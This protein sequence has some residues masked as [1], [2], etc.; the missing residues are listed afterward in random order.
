[1]GGR[2]A[3][4]A[5]EAIGF[6]LT[7]SGAS[8]RYLEGKVLS[9]T[10]A[11]LRL[12]ARFEG[13]RMGIHVAAG[14]QLQAENLLAV[15]AVAL[16]FGLDPEAFRCFETFC[17]VPGR[18]ERILN[19]QNLD[20]F[21]DY[22]HT[23][24]RVDQ[25]PQRAAW[26]GLQA[27]RHRVRLRGQ[28]RPQPSARSWAKPWPGCPT[29]PCLPPTI[30]ATRSPRRSWPTS[31]PASPGA[32]EVFADPDRRRAIEK[33]LELLHPGDALLIAGKGHESTQ[34]IGDVKHPF[35]DQQTVR[36]ILGCA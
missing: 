36:E 11:G 4:M 33:G 15:Q 30:R 26:G 32:A 31:C 6:G 9:S 8:G 13:L 22:A 1:M 14:R 35:S 27:Y 28:P 24:G 18:L 12:H 2:L 25:R 19:P 10:T 7:A 23:P 34:Q 3:G 21:V 20:V 16:G 29:W 17:G 5:P